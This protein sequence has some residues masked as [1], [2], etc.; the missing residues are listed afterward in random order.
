MTYKGA[1]G[2][3]K[4]AALRIGCDQNYLSR[5][6]SQPDRSGHKNI[7]EQYQDRIEDGFNLQAGWLDMPL[8]TPIIQRQGNASKGATYRIPTPSK[9]AHQVQEPTPWPA[10]S[11]LELAIKKLRGLDRDSQMKVIGVIEMLHNNIHPP[12]SSAGLHP[13]AQAA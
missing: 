1:R 9:V 13:P 7:G 8:G 10:E 5:L 11:E 12:H 4:Q 2:Y 3:Q 6:L